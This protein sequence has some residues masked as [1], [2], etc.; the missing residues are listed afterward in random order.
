MLG[1]TEEEAMEKKCCGPAECGTVR[2][3]R[4]SDIDKVRYRT[5][6][7]SMC[8]AWRWVPAHRPEMCNGNEKPR[9]YCGLAG[10]C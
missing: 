10:P 2:V 8:A 5:C 9:G 6:D 3:I 7:G 1:L 4:Y